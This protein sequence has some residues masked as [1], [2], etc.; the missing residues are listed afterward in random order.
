MGKYTLDGST[1]RTIVLVAA[2][3]AVSALCWHGTVDGQAF[4]GVVS[5]VLGGVV[6]A[7][8]TNQGAQAGGTDP[9][10]KT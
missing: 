10:P 7:S 6:H 5:L 3:G 8:G 2:L 9:P 4:V 1:S